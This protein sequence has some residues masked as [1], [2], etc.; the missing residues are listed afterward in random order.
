MMTPE[1]RDLLAQL[2]ALVSQASSETDGA[3]LTT[4]V[5]HIKGFVRLI[6]CKVSQRRNRI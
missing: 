2:A 5:R 4:Q 1:I 6:E 3:K